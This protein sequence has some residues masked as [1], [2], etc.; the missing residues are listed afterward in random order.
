MS[1]LTEVDGPSGS[2]LA[3]GMDRDLPGFRQ[4]V[5]GRA[6]GQCRAVTLAAEMQLDDVAES[7]RTGAA[8]D[9]AQQGSGLVVREMA[10][11]AQDA[12][13]Q[14]GVAAARA[15]HR[16]VVVEFECKQIDVLQDADQLRV[17]A[18]E[19]SAA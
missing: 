9:F 11:I 12:G 15:L 13:D 14:T 5:P 10:F 3:G 19:E 18:T 2:V 4:D 8:N 1:T 6:Q 16:H 17:P 7:A